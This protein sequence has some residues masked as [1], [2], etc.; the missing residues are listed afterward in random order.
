VYQEKENEIKTKDI[1]R[2]RLSPNG[3]F[4]SSH[5]HRLQLLFA[6]S[7]LR[8]TRQKRRLRVR[9]KEKITHQSVS[10]FASHTRILFVA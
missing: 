8:K 4:S 6:I 7:P 2:E 3:L 10:L 1:E 5:P 9:E